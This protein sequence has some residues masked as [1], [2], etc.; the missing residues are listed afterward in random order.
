MARS[1]IRVSSGRPLFDIYS[2]GRK[3]AQ[4]SSINFHLNHAQIAHI[5]RTVGRTTEVVVKV[6]GGGT[7]AGAVAAHFEYISR[8]GELEIETDEG[9]R[10]PK[11]QHKEFL[12][13]WFLDLIRVSIAAAATEKRTPARSS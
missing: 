3:G 6:T 5:R 4:Q 2:A 8:E 13:H 11:Q 9:E 12:A 7:S 1:P 10:I